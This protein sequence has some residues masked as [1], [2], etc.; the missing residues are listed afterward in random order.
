MKSRFTYFLFSN[1]GHRNPNL[2]SRTLKLAKVAHFL[3][4][5][6]LAK[7]GERALTQTA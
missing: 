7:L 5:A 1:Q 4:L 2:S 3:E 6:R